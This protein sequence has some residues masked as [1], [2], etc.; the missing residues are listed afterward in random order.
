MGD[1]SS[2]PPQ[3]IPRD[4]AKTRLRAP[5]AGARRAQPARVGAG[6]GTPPRGEEAVAL[7]APRRRPESR[8][9]R[10]GRAPAPWRTMQRAATA[11][12]PSRSRWSWT[13]SGPRSARLRRRCVSQGAAGG[14]EARG[15]R[16]AGGWGCRGGLFTG[17]IILH[18]RRFLFGGPPRAAARAAL[19]APLARAPPSSRAVAPFGS[20]PAHARDHMLR[21]ARLALPHSGFSAGEWGRRP[22]A[23]NRTASLPWACV[24]H[25]RW[26]C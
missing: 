22:R 23:G 3:P 15:A 24:P 25:V 20:I 6:C 21:A 16:R 1:L 13:T 9:R 11:A 10:R 4:A 14:R 7:G 5:S 19:S 2:A 17:E 18:A 12:G 8:A 26:H